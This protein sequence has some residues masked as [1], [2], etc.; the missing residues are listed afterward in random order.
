MFCT[1]NVHRQ[2]QKGF[3]RLVMAHI[4]ASIPCTL[5]PLQ[6]A[7]YSNRSREKKNPSLFTQYCFRP[8]PRPNLGLNQEPSEHSIA[9]VPLLALTWA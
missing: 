4:K 2:S 8:S 5:D 9:S 1:L 6:F 3:E 7:Y